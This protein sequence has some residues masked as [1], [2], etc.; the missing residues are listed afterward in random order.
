MLTP[1]C[2]EMNSKS[3]CIEA[4][5]FI[6]LKTCFVY[7][8]DKYRCKNEKKYHDAN[9]FDTASDENVIVKAWITSNIY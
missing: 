8:E 4:Q 3:F 2:L 7:R 1:F 6:C 5:N 9:C